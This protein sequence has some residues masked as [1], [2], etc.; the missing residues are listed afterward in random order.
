MSDHSNQQFYLIE[1]EHASAII[2]DYRQAHQ[3]QIAQLTELA[4]EKVSHGQVGVAFAGQSV[5]YIGVYVATAPNAPGWKADPKTP[6]LFVP[7]R[8]LKAGRELA[9]RLTA[10]DA[11]S[12]LHA[13]K[14]HGVNPWQES[15]PFR[16][17]SAG[18]GSFGDKVIVIWGKDW[19]DHHWP[20]W[21]KPIKTSEAYA[22]QEAHQETDGE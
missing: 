1:G 6:G 19:G 8:R 15:E 10:M 5:R 3:R 13:L 2:D 7:N 20:D 18:Y 9:D 14:R 22:I 17:R 21:V 4:G 16:M 12:F 11:G